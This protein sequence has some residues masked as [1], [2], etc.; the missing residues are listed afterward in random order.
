MIERTTKTG[1][2]RLMKSGLD[3][4]MRRKVHREMRGSYCS[5]IMMGLRAAL[6]PG[7]VCI[8]LG[9]NIGEVTVPLAET[10]ATVHAFEPDPDTFA[11]LMSAC[12]RHPSAML[13]QKAAGTQ[14]CVMSLFRSTI[15]DKDA[16]KGA[17]GSTLIATNTVANVENSVEVEVIDAV[18]LVRS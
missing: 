13:H 16:R 6:G 4:Q 3:V 1:L 9:A 7:D 2:K 5:G 12:A 14:P 8:A 18:A 10:G 17:T 11:Q 15:L